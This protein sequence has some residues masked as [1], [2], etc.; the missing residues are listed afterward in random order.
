MIRVSKPGKNI[1]KSTEDHLLK[2]IKNGIRPVTKE[3]K[4]CHLLRDEDPFDPKSPYGIILR[5]PYGMSTD[6]D[7]LGQEGYI[8][9]TK[10]T[11]NELLLQVVRLY[12]RDKKYSITYLSREVSKK[13]RGKM[14][15]VTR[16]FVN[17]QSKERWSV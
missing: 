16:R 14:R 17:I 9:R 6:L 15:M 5:I 11:T 2:A 13:V 8:V 4:W 10:K 7:E 12:K 3:D 1:S